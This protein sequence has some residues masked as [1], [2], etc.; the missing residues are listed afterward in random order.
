[1]KKVISIMLFAVLTFTMLSACGGEPLTLM[2]FMSSETNS[3]LDFGGAQ[4]ITTGGW[5][6]FYPK[7]ESELD[8]IDTDRRLYRTAQVEK[9]LNVDLVQDF[10]EQSEVASHY[11]T[12]YVAN[13]LPYHTS[14]QGGTPNPIYE[15]Y[16]S[17]IL[18][19]LDYIPAIDLSDEEIYGT[20]QG[21]RATT[22]D[23]MSYALTGSSKDEG[24]DRGFLAYNDYL[25]KS[26]G[27]ADPQ[28]LYEQGL[29]TFETFAEMLTLVSDMSNPD[30]LIYGLTLYNDPQMLPFCAVFAN[31]GQV[32]KQDANGK[33][34]FALEDREA[35]EALQW[36]SDLHVESDV[37]LESYPPSLFKKGQATFYLGRSWNVQ[38]ALDEDSHVEEF[39]YIPFPYGPSGEY[40]VSTASYASESG[41]TVFFNCNDTEF[42]GTVMDYYLRFDDY[43]DNLQ[44]DEAEYDMLNNFW[45]QESYEHYTKA[46]KMSEYDYFSQIG[47]E[48]YNEFAGELHEATV[49]TKNLSTVMDSYA[50]L[51][52]A[53][54]DESLNN[55]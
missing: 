14:N 10:D 1:M 9:A 17:G 19:P 41:G 53:A 23:G 11:F 43:P 3:I 24:T 16:K 47:S 6:Y 42:A 32:V 31:G 45:S 49:G 46:K 37:I 22:F 29:W 52:Q 7:D 38:N 48:L 2:D 26:F 8:S 40:G 33:Y 21:R 50:D 5:S 30:N 54:L 15:M 4:F 35:M 55:N 51:I 39:Y 18:E 25:I 27:V 20:E 36:V 34:V 13:N 12:L 44:K 28:E